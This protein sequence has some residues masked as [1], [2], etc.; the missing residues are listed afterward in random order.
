MGDAVTADPLDPVEALRLYWHPPLTQP[1]GERMDR[2]ARRR[3]AR[4]EAK[5]YPKTF[6]DAFIPGRVGPV[7]LPPFSALTPAGIE[8]V[9]VM[10]Y[11]GNAVE[12]VRQRRRHIA[13]INNNLKGYEHGA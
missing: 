3:E 6:L 4:A 9:W 12:I 2:A 5:S 8:Q 13:R 10:N 1:K 7:Y 11:D